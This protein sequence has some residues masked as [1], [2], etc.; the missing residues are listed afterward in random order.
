MST[1]FRERNPV[2]IG[3]ISI[4]VIIAFILIAFK[5]GSLPIIGGGDTYHASFSDSSGLK[6]NDEVRIAG[7]RVGKVTGV[8]L[9]DGHVEVTFKIR[10]S[11]HFGTETGAQI[12]VKTLLGAMFLALEPAGPGQLKKGS[13]IPVSRTRS[14][15]DVV[16][17]FSGLA[18]RAEKINLDQLSTS[19]NDLSA[20]TANTPAA[21]KSTLTGLSA[22]SANVA[23]RD[24]Q[25]NSL[26]TNL[27]KVSGVLS[28]RDQDIVTL[29]KNSDVLLRAVVA[30]RAAV[31]RLLVSTSQFSTQLTLLVQQSRGDLKPALANLEG[32]VAVLRK[33]QSNLDNS[34]RLLAPF[35]RVFTSTLGT[36]PWFDTWISNLPPTPGLGKNS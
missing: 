20:A 10:T 4:L 23:A 15:Y 35:Y 16:Q 14:A 29:M 2:P 32:V 17:A 24:G 3:A 11:S 6:A 9:N 8:T 34:L 27:R 12:K 19:L 5:A 36:G 33:N 18:D 26:L 30:R 1:P 7:V 22:L 13:T 31:H 21:L 25:I 28:T